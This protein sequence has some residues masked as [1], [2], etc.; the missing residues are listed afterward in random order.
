[1][2]FVRGNEEGSGGTPP[3]LRKKQ[4]YSKGPLGE[5]VI[6]WSNLGF[7]VMEATE[8]NECEA[9]NSLNY[10][11]FK[12]SSFSLARPLGDLRAAST[13]SIFRTTTTMGSYLGDME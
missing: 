13:L 12:G 8:R 9:S 11:Q 2:T 7:D 4:W 5:F 3:S 1:M 10:P 6:C